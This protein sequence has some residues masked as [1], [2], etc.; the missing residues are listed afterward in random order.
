MR[1]YQIPTDKNQI[2]RAQKEIEEADRLAAKANASTQN[3]RELLTEYNQQKERLDNWKKI[4]ST[5]PVIIFTVFFIIVSITEYLFSKE[6]YREVSDQFPWIVA[7]GLFAAGIGI[8][9]MIAYKLDKNKRAWKKY[10]I[11]NDPN[12]DNLTNDEKEAEIESFTRSRF[13]FGVILALFLLVGIGYMSKLRVEEEIM[14]GIR[15]SKF[16]LMDILPVLLY[17]FEIIFGIYVVYLFKKIK[18]GLYVNKLRKK[19]DQTVAKVSE[20]TRL[21]IRK[22]DDAIREDINPFEF[23]SS[24][25]LHTATYRNK[26]FT[27]DNKEE[28]IA[29]AQHMEDVFNIQLFDT[30]NN[31]LEMNI[32]VLTDYKITMSGSTNKDGHLSLH[33]EKTYPLDSVKK[34]FIR[35]SASADEYIVVEGNYDLDKNKVHKIVIDEF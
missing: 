33:I 31:P 32:S 10:E 27:L 6:I 16:G 35:K 24:D 11:D 15:E 3:A 2:I 7:I 22:I 14:A 29:E 1:T 4:M 8:S 21:A 20:L 12:K 13:I 34:I 9:E 28:Y 30:Q 19:F 26:R 25:N 23:N 17:L 18:L 5:S